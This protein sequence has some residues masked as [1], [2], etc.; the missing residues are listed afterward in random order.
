M[1]VAFVAASLV[2]GGAGYHW[3]AGLG[4]LDAF[5]NASMILTGMGPIAPLATPASKLFAIAYTLYSALAFL[6]VAAVL[7]GPVL[8]RLVHRVHLD[9]YGDGTSEEG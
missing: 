5:L 3:L 9:L 4:W 7:V 8:T 2:L 6:T 1:A